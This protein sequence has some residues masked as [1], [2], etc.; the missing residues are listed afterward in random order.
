M[1]DVL[2]LFLI[3]D[4]EDIALLI[5]KSLER[6]RHH[7]TAA[8]PPPTPSSSWATPRSTWSSSI[9]QLPDMSGLDLLQT[10]ARE[11]IAAPVLMV[12]VYADDELAASVLRAG[13]LDYVVKDPSLAFLGELPKRVVES[14]TRHRLEQMNRLL[15]QALESAAT[16]S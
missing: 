4:D 3:E 12:T 1:T 16:A 11:G 7:V 15:I 8:A 2:R 5:R 14:V 6:D 10:L 13:A 9:R